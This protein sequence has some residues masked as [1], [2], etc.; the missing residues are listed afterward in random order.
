MHLA[1]GLL[2]CACAGA[3][4]GGAGDADDVPR[5]RGRAPLRRED[6]V[7]VTRFADV[8]AV[9]VSRRM[10]YVATPAGLGIYDRQFSSWLPPLS[11]ADGFPQG[12]VRVMAGDPGSDGV[13][14]GAF[15]ELLYYQPNID[16]LVRTPVPGSVERIIFD[17]RSPGSGA[18]VY[19]TGSG[20]LRA[21]TTG[22][23]QP[24]S[25]AMLPPP[26]DRVVPSSLQEIYREFPTVESFERM[27]TRDDQLRTWPVTAGARSPER[28]EV[29]LGTM[30]NGLFKVDPYFNQGTHLPFGLLDYGAGALALAADGIWV[31]G[32]G[33]EVT[34]AGSRPGLTFASEDLQDWRW[35]EA[36]V[37]AQLAGARA[38]DLEVRGSIAWI[39]TDRGVARVDTRNAND[40]LTLS[41]I[42]GLPSDVVL[43][44]S[45]RESG[46]W[47]GTQRGLVFVADSGGGRRRPRMTVSEMV[48]RDIPV[49]ALLPAGDT[50][51][52]GSDAGL[53]LLRTGDEQASR[54]AP[55]AGDARLTQPVSALAR[56]DSLLVAAVGS[57][58]VVMNLR[59][60]A[61]VRP[62]EAVN[63]GLLGGIRTLAMDERTLWAGGPLG[64]VVVT[65][66]NGTSRFLPIPAEVA[67][68]VYDI[69]LSRNFAWI[70]TRRGIQRLRR[71]GDGTVW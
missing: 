59:G 46:A 41:A 12:R 11:L 64:V 58:V 49:R 37:G 40:F 38:Y 50:L 26:A 31:G 19:A 65:R 34:G 23:T 63:F 30:G 70:A 69:A 44:V 6:R 39:A 55:D 1:I 57:Q 28:S 14:I 7:L 10:V 27:L 47:V 36:P 71:F 29:W 66:A 33:Q 52:I 21:S 45:A 3:G 48:A 61:I 8:S 24:V 5:P 16:Q 22:F 15:G 35:V 18:F 2:L 20:W 17:R 60:G 51:W 13:Y 68:D 56:S 62:W 25:D 43:S 53:L 4:Q 42:N 67:A 54:A 32:L 9:A